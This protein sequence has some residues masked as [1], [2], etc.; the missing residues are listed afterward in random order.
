MEF[1]VW[2]KAKS[3][4]AAKVQRISKAAIWQP[5]VKKKKKV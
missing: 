4:W 5:G 3:C 1:A 2:G